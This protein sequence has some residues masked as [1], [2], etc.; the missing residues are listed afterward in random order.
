MPFQRQTYI[1]ASKLY[2]NY[3]KRATHIAHPFSSMKFIVLKCI[4]YTSVDCDRLWNNRVAERTLESQ[5]IRQV[6]AGLNG[7]LRLHSGCKL[8]FSVFLIKIV[9]LIFFTVPCSHLS[10]KHT[11]DVWTCTK[12]QLDV[13]VNRNPEIDEDRNCKRVEMTFEFSFSL[14]EEFP[15]Q[16]IFNNQC[17]L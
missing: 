9:Y 2:Y 8:V 6:V 1:F 17:F 16:N 11:L 3:K 7:N 4:S 5:R 14:L 10:S 13:V 15:L 12:T